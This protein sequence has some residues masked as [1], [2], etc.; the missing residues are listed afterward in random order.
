LGEAGSDVRRIGQTS[1]ILKRSTFSSLRI[2][3]S[4]WLSLIKLFELSASVWKA[5]YDISPKR[6]LFQNHLF[7]EIYKIS[8]INN[9]CS[10]IIV[11]GSVHKWKEKI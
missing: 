11:G 3:P 7:N 9:D 2:A 1:W 8:N 6:A 5:S 4:Q 10:R